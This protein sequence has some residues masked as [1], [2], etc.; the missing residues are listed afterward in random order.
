MKTILLLT[1]FLFITLICDAQI[2]TSEINLTNRIPVIL[3]HKKPSRQLPFKINNV[4]IIDARYDTCGIGYLSS[5][6]HIIKTGVKLSTYGKISKNG[7]PKIYSFTASA[8][9][10]IDNWVS[11]HLQVAES[12]SGNKKLLIVIKK[13]WLTSAA[14]PALN[15]NG[16]K[17]QQNQG[18]DKGIIC[19]LEFY[20][21]NENIYY[22]LYRVDS[23]YTLKDDVA[24]DN[25]LF[26]TTVLISTM[27]KLFTINTDNIIAKGRKLSFNDI[28][29]NYKK[30]QDLPILNASVFTKGVYKTFEEFKMNAP[31]LKEYEFREGEMGDLLYVKNDGTEYPERNAWGFC[32]GKNLFINSGDKYSSL[33]KNQHT[34]YFE[35]LKGIERKAKH[36]VPYT[37]LFNVITNTGRK[38]TKFKGILKYYQ[39]DMETGEVF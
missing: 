26:I 34:F 8:D 14:A 18:W 35:G 13:L 28:Q 29:A 11:A 5:A 36:D 22:P 37:S 21:E 4:N 17:G 7:W 9:S 2:K 19:K 25:E 31:S 38:V 10:A 6:N 24:D 12:S 30:Q 1:A 20:L 16:K 23:I 27:D 39:V 33:I 32:D 3:E 15:E